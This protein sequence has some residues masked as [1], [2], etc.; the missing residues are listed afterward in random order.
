MAVFSISL[1]SVVQL[2]KDSDGRLSVSSLSCDTQV[3]D[4]DIQFRG[5]AR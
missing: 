3:G 1:T 2:G 4:V 5:G